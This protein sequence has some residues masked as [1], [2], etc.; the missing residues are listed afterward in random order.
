MVNFHSNPKEMQCQIIFKILHNCPHLTYQQ[1][2][3]ENFPSLA[4]AVYESRSSRCSSQI[5]KRQRNQR[6]NC[7]CLLDHRKKQESSRNISTSA[8]L[9]ML[10]PLTVWI[11]TNCEKFFKRW[12]YQATY[13]P[14]E[15][16]VCR[17]KSNSQNW[18]WDNE[19]VTN[20]D[21][22]TSRLYIVTL[23]I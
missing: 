14:P 13:L 20:Y 7:Q 19:L 23:L 9:T 11:I 12:E 10:T 22:S 15:K 18:T 5:Q 3:A 8:L 16:P 21:R 1:G 17:S 2:N 4:S 6:S